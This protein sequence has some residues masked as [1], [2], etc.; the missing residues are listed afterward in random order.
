MKI[1]TVQS[2]RGADAAA[3]VITQ[4]MIHMGFVISNKRAL[5]ISYD[6][7]ARSATLECNDLETLKFFKVFGTEML[8]NAIKRY[9]WS[10]DVEGH[11]IHPVV[12]RTPP[13]SRQ[14]YI[15][16]IPINMMEE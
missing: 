16:I 11:L 5:T 4:L 3:Q 6:A 15:G 7:L 14:F 8:S 1:I 12:F 2:A 9:Y 10:K 13:K